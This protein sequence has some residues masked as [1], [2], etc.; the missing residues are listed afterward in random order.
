MRKWCQILG[1]LRQLEFIWQSTR[2]KRAVYRITLE[3]WSGLPLLNITAFS[4]ILFS[5]VSWGKYLR[6]GKVQSKRIRGTGN[7][8]LERARNSV[9]SQQSDWNKI[10]SRRT[11]NWICKIITPQKWEIIS[12]GWNTAVKNLSFLTNLKSKFCK[13][14][15][16][17][18]VTASQ[19]KIQNIYRN[20]KI[21]P[22]G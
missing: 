11:L 8:R 13:L 15:N 20:A 5:I 22:K 14:S 6:W 17:V 16:C 1:K 12:S 19:N 10:M 4:W 2:K 18:Q 7:Q 21:A 9:W 3:N